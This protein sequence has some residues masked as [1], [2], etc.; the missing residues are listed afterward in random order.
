MCLPACAAR[1]LEWVTQPGPHPRLRPAI[2]PGD[3]TSLGSSP[4]PFPPIHA[5]R[6]VDL[7]HTID[8]DFPTYGGESQFEARV[9]ARHDPDGW[10]FRE[11][12]LQEH[13]GTHLDAPIH[14]AAGPSADLIPAAALV[15][16]LAVIEIRSRAA[17]DPDA[18]LT[19]DDLRQWERRHGR[20]PDGA[21][22]ALDSGWDAHARAPKFR[23]ADATGCLHFPGIHPEVAAFLLAERQVK[24]LMVDTL[25]LDHGPSTEFPTHTAW[26]GSGRW[27]LECA[28][29]LGELPAHGAFVIVGAPKVSGAS[30][31][32]SRVLALVP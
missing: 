10:F 5:R 28:A 26:L 31:G 7:T 3:V 18:L 12:R 2:V 4:G 15:G 21:I 32:P 24:G 27:G 19:I 17:K 6:V 14:R 30:G 1:L 25:S 23:G 22:V 29:N 20:L 8:P 11:W 13:T 16:P 9:L